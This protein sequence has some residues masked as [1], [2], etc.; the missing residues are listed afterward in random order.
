MTIELRRLSDQLWEIPKR[1]G[2]R[3]PGRIYASARQIDELRE[4]PCLGQ[5]MNVAHLPGIVGYALAMPD[6]HWGYGFPIGGV[7]A[8][9]LEDGVVSP[10]AVGYDIN[11]GVRLARTRLSFPDVQDR[12]PDLIRDLFQTIPCGVGTSGAIAKLSA[13]EVKRVLERGASWAVEKGF[14][15]P[16]D[17]EGAEERGRLDDADPAAVSETAIERGA[18]QLG[19]LGSGNHFLEIDVVDEIHLPEVAARFG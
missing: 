1:G 18:Q 17:L 3:V 8:M 11:C 7:A 5:V 4:D 12:I 15:D 19:T 13:K 16:N 10:G 6:I 14:G 2:M 9:R